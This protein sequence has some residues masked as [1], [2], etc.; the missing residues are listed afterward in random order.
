M[1][2]FIANNTVLLRDLML[3]EPNE[4]AFYVA[5]LFSNG[6]PLNVAVDEQVPRDKESL[7]HSK[8]LQYE[9]WM[10]VLEKAWTKLVGGYDVACGLSPEDAFEEILGAPAYSYIIL[11][12]DRRSRENFEFLIRR[13]KSENMCV[14]L[15]AR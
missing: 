15:T 10:F 14:I 12:E 13:K 9:L 8:P 3:V 6:A 7:L 11:A 2:C 1:F 4:S 5:K